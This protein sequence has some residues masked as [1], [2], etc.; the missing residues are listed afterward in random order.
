MYQ[1][2]A[3]TRSCLGRTEEHLEPWL[4][5]LEFTTPTFLQRACATATGILLCFSIR[6]T[7][8]SSHCH[9]CWRACA[10][11]KHNLC[12]N[13]LVTFCDYSFFCKIYD[14]SKLVAVNLGYSFA[15]YCPFPAP[16]WTP[17]AY[18]ASTFSACANCKPMD[19]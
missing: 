14:N 17:S 16:A 3:Y 8:V 2:N 7:T 9:Q 13:E 11:V 5:L 19:A 4:M 6:H 1:R 15:V 10:K 18:L 12:R